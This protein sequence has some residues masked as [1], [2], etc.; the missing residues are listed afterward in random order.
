MTIHGFGNS[1]R[2]FIYVDD[3]SRAIEIIFLKGEIQTT[4]NI[5]SDDEFSVNDIAKELL[6]RFYPQENI[7][8][9]IKLIKDRNFNDCRYSVN[10]DRLKNL[11]WE[12][13]INFEDGI[14]RTIKWYL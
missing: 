10:C 13:E 12:K 4:Y 7:K 11:G 14:Q 5:G 6:K 9:W 2:N 8:D 3:V 1:V